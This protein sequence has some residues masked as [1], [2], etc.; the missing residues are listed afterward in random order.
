MIKMFSLSIAVCMGIVASASAQVITPNGVSPKPA[1]VVVSQTFILSEISSIGVD[2][3][4]LTDMKAPGQR[5]EIKALYQKTFNCPPNLF[6]ALALPQ[7]PR[8]VT[9]V[10]RESVLANTA[11]KARVLNTCRRTIEQ[12]GPGSKV[13]ITGRITETKDGTRLF[14]NSLESCSVGSAPQ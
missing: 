13:L 8:E 10:L 4:T 12:A 14:L 9:V 2:S 3:L 11:V 7:F 5:H 1:P 6:C